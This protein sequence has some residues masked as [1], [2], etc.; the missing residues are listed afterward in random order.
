MEFNFIQSIIYAFVSG[1]AEF[2]PV[3]ADAT[4][5]ILRTLFASGSNTIALDFVI[6]LAA[7]VAVYINCQSHISALLRT[8]RLLQIPRHRR[9]KEVDPRFAAELRLI[10]SAMVPAV[11]LV[12][13]RGAVLTLF[14]RLYLVSA[15]LLL[16]GLALYATGRIPLGN[17][18]AGLMT[19][20]DGV[21]YG[22]SSGLGVFPGV[23]RVGFGM[24]YGMMRGASAQN[25]FEWAMILSLPVLAALCV[26]DIVVMFRVGVGLFGFLIFL[27]C[28]VSAVFAYMGTSL[29][30]RLMRNLVQQINLSVF[31][32][33]CWGM[34]FF[35]FLLYMI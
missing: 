8:N 9:K 16:N 34:A 28:L 13:F 10:K 3:S 32:Y 1:L 2:F 21:L 18:N 7:L 35:S 5:S 23:S 31:S 27:Q 26:A 11:I 14:T 25:I 24:A 4:Q 33:I 22:V 30:I 6:H 19:R 17:K 12:I 20:L 29:A 15:C